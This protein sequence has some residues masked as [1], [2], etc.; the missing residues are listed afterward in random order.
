[1]SLRETLPD[2]WYAFQQQLF[3][4]LETAFGPLSGRYGL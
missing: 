2:Y 4:R 1:M 3:P